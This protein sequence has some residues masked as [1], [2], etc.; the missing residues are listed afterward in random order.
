MRMMSMASMV[1]SV[2]LLAGACTPRTKRVGYVGGT[3]LAVAGAAV[4]GGAL[5]SFSRVCEHPIPCII[6]GPPLL[7]AG[8]AGVGI[9]V[10]GLLVLLSARAAASESRTPDA[11]N[12]VPRPAPSPATSEEEERSAV[13]LVPRGPA[14][15]AV[16]LGFD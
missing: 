16:R 4:T 1:V 12:A 14:P 15:A 8:A 6:A 7:G 5:V 11:P 13:T 3:A 10:T 9:G 2:S